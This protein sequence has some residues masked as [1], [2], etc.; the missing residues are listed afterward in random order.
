M[1][2]VI[3]TNILVSA[4]W[5]PAGNASLLLS[6]VISG[7]IQACYDHRM[8]SEY[9]EVLTCPRFGFPPEQVDLLLAVIIEDGISVV[10]DSLPSITLPD[11]DD[12]PF[13]EVARYC[14]APLITGN[15]RHFPDDPRVISLAEFCN[16]YL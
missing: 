6:H 11:E 14:R 16:K 12:R 8:I 1:I 3:D 7:R 4:L 9:R 13:Y 10:P 5:K 15:L 2:A